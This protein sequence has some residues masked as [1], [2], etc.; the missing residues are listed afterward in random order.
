MKWDESIQEICKSLYRIKATCS[1]GSFIGTGFIVANY[2][3][4]KKGDFKFVLATAK[5][6]VEKLPNHETIYWNIERYDLRGNKVEEINF[7]SNSETTGKT[8]YSF[9]ND[10]DIAV[11]FVPNQ[12]ENH[13]QP[14]RTIDPNILIE[15]GTKVGWAGFPLFAERKT[16]RTHPC[17]FEGVVST[18][19]ELSPKLFYLVDGHG[20]KGVSG[21]PIWHWNEEESNYEIIGL[22]S[23]YLFAEAKGLPGLVAF[24]SINHILVYLKTSNELDFNIIERKTNGV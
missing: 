5:H 13:S 11:V 14:L 22:C 18:T 23:Q 19:V 24:E 6:L 3:E 4:S 16:L 7:K 21:G 17:Y 1:L 15:P 20:G 8:P 12:S 9:H 2:K 10:Y